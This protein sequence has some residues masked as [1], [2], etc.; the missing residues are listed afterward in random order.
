MSQLVGCK[1]QGG[2][3]GS[4]GTAGLHGSRPLGQQELLPPARA[5][6]TA[7]GER[8]REEARCSVCLDFL[9]EP[10]SVDCGHSFCLR[11]ISEF[12][13]K[14]DSAQGGVYACPQCRGPF[15]PASF[16]PNRQLASL[17]DSV[18][19]LGLGT[20]H[21][22]TRQCARHGED[23]SR[24]CEEDHTLLCWVCDTSPEHQSHRTEPLQEAASR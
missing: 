18:R 8:L 4:L 15:R 5:M 10:I 11:C 12:C 21:P 23:L 16:R 24:F 7:P 14:S 9:Q 2:Q 17:V 3:T 22:G 20:G 13:E 1:E 6:A 19:Q